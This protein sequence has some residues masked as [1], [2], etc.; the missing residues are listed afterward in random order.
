MK[1][2]LRYDSSMTDVSDVA[3][4]VFGELVKLTAPVL[5]AYQCD[6]YHDALWLSANL[7]GT[8]YEFPYSFD[9]SGT[10]LIVDPPI[11]IREHAYRIRVCVTEGTA[12]FDAVP[13]TV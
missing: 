12:W 5:I 9:Q 2:R 4:L 13:Y 8:E 11:A 7:K 10:S 3:A 6:L 1:K